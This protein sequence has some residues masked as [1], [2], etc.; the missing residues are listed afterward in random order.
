MFNPTHPLSAV[1]LITFLALPVP[2][3]APTGATF[4]VEYSFQ[5]MIVR[6]DGSDAKFVPCMSLSGNF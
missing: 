2:G 5:G 4:A 3:K 1:Y 6:R